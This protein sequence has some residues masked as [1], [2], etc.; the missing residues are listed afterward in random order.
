MKLEF[1]RASYYLL[2]PPAD[3]TNL[4]AD[5]EQYLKSFR[6]TRGTRRPVVQIQYQ[7]P[8][9]IVYRGTIS[10]RE[11]VPILRDT[12]VKEVTLEVREKRRS[13]LYRGRA[14]NYCG[15]RQPAD[16][17][18]CTSIRSLHQGRRGAFI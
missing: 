2:P 12:G 18:N 7:S 6:L 16:G 15:S 10:S 5:R 8:Q 13:S 3:E 1:E 14:M 9:N 4:I 17:R 11:L